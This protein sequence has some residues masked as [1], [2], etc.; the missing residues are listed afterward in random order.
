MVNQGAALVNDKTY[1][2]HKKTCK[3]WREESITSHTAS[4]PLQL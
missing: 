1:N 3:T 2:P 4:R